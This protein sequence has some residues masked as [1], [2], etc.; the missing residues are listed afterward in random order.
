MPWGDNE[1]LKQWHV[2]MTSAR[3][4]SVELQEYPSGGKAVV[5]VS[6][7]MG[8]ERAVGIAVPGPMLERLLAVVTE[9]VEL[10]KAGG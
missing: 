4:I 1:V 8:A 5:L 9:A 3:S 7:R 10:A 6:A 2:G